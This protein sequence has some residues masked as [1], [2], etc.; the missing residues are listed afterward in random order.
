[1]GWNRTASLHGRLEG[2]TEMFS[3]SAVST[4]S[5]DPVHSCHKSGCLVLSQSI[6]AENTPITFMRSSLAMPLRWS[7]HHG[8]QADEME[9]LPRRRDR[10]CQDVPHPPNLARERQRHVHP[11]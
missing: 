5:V 6:T 1:M 2:G 7:V 3:P 9:S 11:D 4:P 10:G 8:S